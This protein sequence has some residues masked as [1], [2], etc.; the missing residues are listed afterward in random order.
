ML[1]ED[2]LQ[3]PERGAVVSASLVFSTLMPVVSEFGIAIK[4]P[5]GSYQRASRGLELMLKTNAD[6]IVG[7]RDPDLFPAEIAD[8]LRHSDLQVMRGESVTREELRIPVAD[9]ILTTQW[10]KFPILCAEGVVCAIGLI[11]LNQNVQDELD[12]MRR[13]IEQLR[14]AND[15]LH[16]DLV[17]V[18]RQAS[19]DRLTGTWNRHRL[20]ETIVGEMERFRRRSE[21]MSL[22]I[23]DVDM[24]KDVNDRFGH[25]VGDKVLTILAGTIQ[26]NLRATDSL[27]RWGGEEFVVLSPGTSLSAMLLLA[28]RLREQVARTV[29]PY[30]E[31]ITVSI[32]VAQSLQGETWEGWFQRAD[33]ALYLAKAGGRNQVQFAPESEW[34]NNIEDSLQRGFVNLVWHPA[35]DSGDDFLDEQHHGLFDLVNNSL[36]A[37]LDQ[38]PQ[39]EIEAFID[40]LIKDTAQHFED[41]ESLL[42]EIAYPGLP[43]HAF[44][45]ADLIDAVVQLAVRYHSNVA[46]VGELFLFLAHEVVAKHL[47]TDDR[48]FFP[49]LRKVAARHSASGAKKGCV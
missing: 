35:Y 9:R 46:H 30:V 21:P 33:A 26:S 48:E 7:K 12:G 34:E 10:I 1:N 24:F 42:A 28:E 27:A 6:Q 14:I 29:F 36:S 11:V 38:R 2:L 17:E 37:I 4:D 43:E 22:L 47:L 25:L 5:G 40:R 44:K 49:Y 20:E 8:R 31:T 15:L 16:G 39:D 3:N 32:G 41:E 45:H 13:T 23:I 19:T 18:E